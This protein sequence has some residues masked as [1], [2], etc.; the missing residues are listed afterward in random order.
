MHASVGI[1]TE[2]GGM[3]SHAALVARGWGKCCIVGCDSLKI[4]FKDETIRF[5]GCDQVFKKG[6]VIS[7]NGAKGLVYDGAIATM[8]A[9]EN[10]LFTK[11][12]ALCDKYRKLGVRTNADTPEDAARAI[13]FGAEGIGLFR[14]EHM[15]YGKNS[16]TPL[17][18]LR[19]M[20][21][22]DTDEERKEALAEL[23]VQSSKFKVQ[24]SKFKVQSSRFKVQSS[25][26]KVQSFRFQVANC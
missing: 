3:T 6:D 10:P 12:M 1:L 14:I 16:E 4:N 11:F 5:A 19:K 25:K 23:K 21:L 2:R 15:F 20:I 26:F 22:C 7:L 24:S 18:K 9:T 8:D 13:K 17:S